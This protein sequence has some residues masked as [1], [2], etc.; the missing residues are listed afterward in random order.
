M[1]RARVLVHRRRESFHALLSSRSSFNLHFVMLFFVVIL[2]IDPL[3]VSKRQKWD[4]YGMRTFDHKITCVPVSG[5]R[6]VRREPVSGVGHLS[7]VSSDLCSAARPGT[8]PKSRLQPKTDEKVETQRNA[9][10]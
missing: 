1:Y 10:N 3:G 5:V 9:R 8:N 4:Y 2:T 7:S 6:P